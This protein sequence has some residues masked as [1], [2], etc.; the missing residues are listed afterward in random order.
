MRS[1]YSWIAISRQSCCLVEGCISSTFVGSID[2]SK[3]LSADS[4]LNLSF[5]GF[6]CFFCFSVSTLQ[7]DSLSSFDGTYV[8]LL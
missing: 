4:C 2:V 8:L 6:L 5:L 7:P 1:S 3:F